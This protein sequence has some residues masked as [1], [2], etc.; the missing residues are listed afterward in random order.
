[1]NVTSRVVRSGFSK[2]TFQ[3]EPCASFP[4]SG[5]WKCHGELAKV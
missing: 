5:S 4:L 3:S 1:M 2:G